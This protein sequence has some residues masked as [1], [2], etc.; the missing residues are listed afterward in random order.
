M[1]KNWIKKEVSKTKLRRAKFKI[2]GLTQHIIDHYS[3]LMVLKMLKPDSAVEI[4]RPGIYA[5]VWW[6]GANSHEILM[7]VWNHTIF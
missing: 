1:H 2:Y 6:D 4:R 7:I 3:V 5:H